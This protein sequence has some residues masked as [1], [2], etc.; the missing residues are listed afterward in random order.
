MPQTLL[1]MLAAGTLGL[2]TIEGC[3]AQDLAAKKPY[4][5]GNGDYVV[6]P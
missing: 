2:L 5:P 3:D 1:A 6:G 4:G